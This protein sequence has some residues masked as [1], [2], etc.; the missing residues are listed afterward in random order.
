MSLETVQTF[1]SFGECLKYHRQRARLTQDELGLAV[2]YS[3]AHV[4][5]LENNQRLPDVVNVRA[6]FIEAL[7][8]PPDSSAAAQLIKLADTA[9]T[10][11]HTAIADAA[12]RPSGTAIVPQPTH[13]PIALSR[14]IGREHELDELNRLLP[15]TRLLT[16]T[17]AGGIGK[18][19]LA[20]EVAHGFSEMAPDGIWLV[21]LA[22]HTALR[23]LSLVSSPSGMDDDLVAHSVA[24]ALGLQEHDNLT[25]LQLLTT[26]L[27]DKQ[28][29][30]VI[31]NCEHLLNPCAEL[32]AALLHA[33]AGL[34]VLATS[35]EPLRM[36]GEIV[37][38]VPSMTAPDPAHLPA[39]EHMRDYESVELFV[40]VAMANN[41]DWVL[42]AD[43][44][45]S[46]AQICI[47]LDGIPLAIEM[48]AVC[49]MAL[50]VDDIADGLHNRFDLLTNGSRIAL[51]RHQTLRAT[52]DWSY[53]M[54]NAAEKALLTRLA[55]F[56]GGCTMDAIK[57]VCAKL[58]P[59]GQ[60]GAITATPASRA[61]E[62]N[63]AQ[64]SQIV[65]RLVQ[66]SLLFTVSSALPRREATSGAMRYRMLETVRSYASDKLHERGESAAM[67][68][69]HLAWCLNL[70]GDNI[71]LGGHE[72]NAWL[73][74]V[75]PEYEN[76]RAAFA[77]ART[78]DDEGEMMLR[79]VGG[80]RT[81]YWNRGYYAEGLDWVDEALAR[82]GSR[83]S[84]PLI[85]LRA[86]ALLTKGSILWQCGDPDGAYRTGSEALAL[87]KEANDEVGRAWCLV[88]LARVGV[89]SHMDRV[90]QF[91]EE[92]LRLFRQCGAVDGIAHALAALGMIACRQGDSI[93]GSQYLQEALALAREI[94]DVLVICYAFGWWYTLDSEKALAASERELRLERYKEDRYGFTGLLNLHGHKLIAAKQYTRACDTFRETIDFVER[95]GGTDY[96]M[97]NAVADAMSRMSLAE[98]LMGEYGQ[99]ARHIEQADAF[100]IEHGDI[101]SVGT[102][103]ALWSAIMLAQGQ[104]SLPESLRYQRQCGDW[105]IAAWVMN[106]MGWLAR[107]EAQ[108]E[109]AAILIGATEEYMVHKELPSNYTLAHDDSSYASAA[110]RK[111]M[112]NTAFEAA[113]ARGKEMTL[114]QA[115]E[116][117]LAA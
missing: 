93:H 96:M 46:V 57:A 11:T 35:R 17:G 109:R 61:T 25:P 13:L 33:C 2:G 15:E 88:I 24:R 115:V 27:K 89:Y 98:Y 82:S 58:P 106:L 59:V 31:D 79:L 28:S 62:I 104:T 23:P 114:E 102:A 108:W 91:G 75:E 18:T 60:D 32:V 100:Y 105:E 92:A 65:L 14:F 30:L 111:N 70:L 71:D 10:P 85:K 34:R 107:L 16:L 113:Y 56:A 47:R 20:L 95:D 99:A 67:R 64:C 69:H 43:N 77:C 78:R 45:S 4:V 74:S 55:I 83:D 52:L 6:T 9:R 12:L 3:R 51:P 68:E 86:R 54:L 73:K 97:Q 66:K 101:S 63:V 8:L 116:Y 53:D 40:R 36:P 94:G 39:L 37:W 81:F 90:A 50:S 38:R 7:Q 84:R 112:G 41:T 103:E 76:I 48:A 49:V 26:Y 87:L 72:V 21:E 110:C 22:P 19:R 1:S 42:T 44:R 80:L 29:L 5:R 117:A